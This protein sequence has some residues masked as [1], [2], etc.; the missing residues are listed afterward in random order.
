MCEVSFGLDVVV[1][2]DPVDVVTGANLDRQTDF[3]LDGPLP[4]PWYR[5]YNS[6]RNWMP[7]SFGWGHTHD[8]ERRLHFDLD[9]SRLIGPRGTVVAF[10]PIERDG[11]S[12]AAGGCRLRRIDSRSYYLSQAGQPAATFTIL[13]G[14][15]F[16]VLCALTRPGVRV[17]L[18]YDKDGYLDSIIHS[19]GRPVLVEH[20]SAGRVCRLA[21]PTPGG[22]TKQLAAYQ[23]D[24]AGNLVRV[25][26]PYNHTLQ[27]QFDAEHRQVRRVDR[28]GY[29]FVFA[30]D[31]AGRCT[32]AGGEDG[33]D[34]VRLEYAPDHNATLV[35]RAD[36]GQWLYLYDATGIVAKIVAPD[37]SVRQYIKDEAGWINE[38]IDPNGNSTRRLYDTTGAIL[39]TVDPFGRRSDDDARPRHRVA[40]NPAEWDLGD[41][42]NWSPIELPEE[43]GLAALVLDSAVRPF[44]RTRLPSSPPGAVHE[45]DE[46]GL[47]YRESFPDGT[48]RRWTYDP[49][50]NVTRYMDR[51]GRVEAFEYASWN[52]RVMES[53]PL[54][55]RTLYRYAANRHLAAVIDPGGT[56]SEYRY[57]QQDRL[58]EVRR[59][60]KVRETYERDPAGN[61]I[62]KRDG[63]GN[64]LLNFEIGPK[65][66]PVVSRLASG[67]VHTFAYD[68]QGRYLK[69]ATSTFVVTFAYDDS[70]RRTEDLRDG[71]GVTH[72]F[73]RDALEETVVLGRF[74]TRYERVVGGTLAITDPSGARHTVHVFGRGLVKRVLA[75][76]SVEVTQY[77]DGGLCLCRVTSRTAE[78][79]IW[80]RVYRYSPEGNLLAAEDKIRG[81]TRYRYDAA[82]RIAGIHRAHGLDEPIDLDPAGNVLRMPGLRRVELLDGNRLASADDE[83]FEY[84][85]RN[86][87]STRSMP[88][89]TIQYHYNSQD[90][91]VRI[92]WEGQPDWT[93]AYDPLGRRAWKAWGSRKVEYFWDSDRLAAE[94]DET[95]R[96]RVYVYA[97]PF[98]MVPIMFVDYSS[99]DSEMKAGRRYYIHTDQ[100][101]TP[102]LVE[103]DAGRT[104]WSATIDPFGRAHISA[105]SAIEFDLRFPGHF[106]DAEIGLHYNRFRYYDPRLGRYL[107]S[108]PLGIAGGLNL[109]AYMSNPLT[110]VDVRGLT[111]DPPQDQS[112][113][114]PADEGTGDA[115]GGCPPGKKKS[116]QRNGKRR[117]YMGNNPSK[118]SKTY[119]DVVARMEADGKIKEVDGKKVV[120]CSDGTTIPLES[121]NWLTGKT[122]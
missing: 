80:S 56:L 68:P 40:A 6:S 121:T 82:H 91:L 51:E 117:K 14:R 44:I 29:G 53:N 115:D 26:D 21:M 73:G 120:I 65:N 22:R 9:G 28:R 63:A 87:L 79:G 69:A 70:G 5:W 92:R 85:L 60:A 95:S 107:Q 7:G 102:L 109:Y 47:L 104:A 97:D 67:E 118:D 52:L 54:G 75:N 27:Y 50:G 119:K 81:T 106:A 83:Q 96:V 42:P 114:P 76:G 23:Y 25:T 116:R 61:L 34:E 46:F 111:D 3:V 48:S 72:R 110:A 57:S 39:C 31:N 78:N 49:N 74:R 4:L 36:G 15:S 16:A 19:T 66:L 41:L 86:H 99:A 98:A 105:D 77:G 58:T 13:D 17:E 62:L 45:R 101:G 11:D 43:I 55:G 84:N 30:Y 1:V 113:T 24:P 88:R 8:Y 38:E 71:L 112:E 35:T 100:I 89:G 103:D 59:H 33:T 12:A 108:D 32:L 122:A 20:D 37:G 10:P 64:E 93:A 2:G 90:A 94:R 18:R